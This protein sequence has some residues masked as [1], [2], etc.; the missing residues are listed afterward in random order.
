MGLR[1]E[2]D[3][4]TRNEL[5]RMIDSPSDVLDY[6]LDRGYGVSDFYEIGREILT[7]PKTRV[8]KKKR[9]TKR[10]G[11]KKT[12]KVKKKRV[13]AKASPY[14]EKISRDPRNQREIVLQQF[15][16]FKGRAHEGEPAD[17]GN[18]VELVG[19]EFDK[20]GVRL[21][22]NCT[23]EGFVANVLYEEAE[24]S[25]YGKGNNHWLK[26]R[27]NSPVTEEDLENGDLLGVKFGKNDS[28]R[29]AGFLPPENVQ[30]N[31]VLHN[32]AVKGIVKSDERETSYSE[33]PNIDGTPCWDGPEKLVIR[34][35]FIE[36]VEKS[37]FGGLEEIAKKEKERI[38]PYIIR[39]KG[40]A[41][42]ISE[43]EEKL[44]DIDINKITYHVSGKTFWVDK[45]VKRVLGG[46]GRK[47][48]ILGREVKE[49]SYSNNKI[50]MRDVEI[51]FDMRQGKTAAEV[52]V[53]EYKKFKSSVVP[54]S[55]DVQLK[56][57][58]A[59]INTMLIRKKRES[60]NLLKKLNMAKTE[61][62]EL[63]EKISSESN[64]DKSSGTLRYLG[65]EG[66]NFGS[67]LELW[68]QA[69]SNGRNLKV[70]GI[71]PECHYR[72]CNLMDSFI[73]HLK[74][75][76]GRKIELFE[77][78]TSTHGN[79]DE[80]IFLDFVNDPKIKITD[81]GRGKKVHYQDERINFETYLRI[82][83]ELNSEDLRDGN[84]PEKSKEIAGR[85]GISRPFATS[86]VD[87]I[88][89][90]FNVVFLDYFG[91][92]NKK[93]GDVLEQLAI[94]RLEDEAV[95]A[96]TFNASPRLVQSGSPDFIAG[97]AFD[98]VDTILFKKCGFDGVDMI[99][100]NYQDGSD[101]MIFQAY[102][103]K[104]NRNGIN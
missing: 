11:R 73:C 89:G 96:L 86:I 38:K 5:E 40:M 42:S 65:L 98:K 24:F 49:N 103:V 88:P 56:D 15:E 67:Y 45:F 77:G 37:L 26:N 99:S 6:C 69:N 54:E 82:L 71:F 7:T 1:T 66:P 25:K 27:V 20:K 17:F 81:H 28:K 92:I 30:S 8:T 97:E 43:Y 2:L 84:I 44:S 102:H 52:F 100:L 90:K 32:F 94:N 91:K 14:Q 83:D 47:S 78:V 57:D 12:R 16:E 36:F 41:G 76:K 18:L 87:R 59:D 63:D 55:D 19:L 70:K 101:P 31:Y 21:D 58:I 23:R 35:S 62:S 39:R 85:Y 48:K 64:S 75:N 72:Y 93:K 29:I 79:I 68:K 34:N 9:K 60:S 95:V 53:R 61:I 104:K 50:Q 4:L 46:R 80:K 3:K 51:V 22:E 10:E 33:S 74:D 13:T